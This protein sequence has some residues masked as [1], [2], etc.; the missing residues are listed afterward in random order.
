MGTGRARER[1]RDD[2]NRTRETRRKIDRGRGA[3]RGACRKKLFIMVWVGRIKNDSVTSIATEF[4][5]LA[6][7]TQVK[8]VFNL[9]LYRHDDGGGR[10]ASGV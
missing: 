10:V 6:K 3:A 2:V 7:E 1:D 8:N 5:R 9:S 4:S